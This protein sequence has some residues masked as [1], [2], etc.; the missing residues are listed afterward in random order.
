MNPTRGP[1]NLLESLFPCAWDDSISSIFTTPSTFDEGTLEIPDD[2]SLIEP[3]N[4]SLFKPLSPSPFIVNAL[5][6]ENKIEH[7]QQRESLSS[8]RPQNLSEKMVREFYKN[9][10]TPHV[11]NPEKPKKN[12]PKHYKKWTK[13]EGEKLD[14]L[15]RKYQIEKI[16]K[17]GQVSYWGKIAKEMGNLSVT[18]CKKKWTRIK[19]GD[20]PKISL[21]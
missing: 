13:E 9:L 10:E 19:K 2:L 7:F 11:K 18:Q 16:S 4:P 17:I 5:N 8:V 14:I 12:R 20:K 6:V 15:V 1:F 3:L 21:L